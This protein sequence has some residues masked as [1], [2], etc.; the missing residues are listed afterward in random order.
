MS[1]PRIATWLLTA[2]TMPLRSGQ[3]RVRVNESVTAILERRL[4]YQS[5]TTV[6]MDDEHGEYS[7]RPATTRGNGD[8]RRHGH[9][10]R[11]RPGDAPPVRG[12]G[13][14]ARP[15]P[16]GPPGARPDAGLHRPGGRPGG[17]R[18]PRRSSRLS[19]ARERGRGAGLGVGGV[20]AALTG[21]V[22][23]VDI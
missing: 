13:G 11:R 9:D 20:P 3:L 8:H 21:P 18:A 19:P 10:D 14:P 6:D 22:A 5:P 23:P 2:W 15:P 17:R 12:G 1:P 4:I 7:P 16:R